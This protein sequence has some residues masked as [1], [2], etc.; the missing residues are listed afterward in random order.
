MS[1]IYSTDRATSLLMQ[2]RDICNNLLVNN[3]SLGNDIDQKSIVS[4]T[5]SPTTDIVYIYCKNDYTANILYKQLKK[6]LYTDN[7]MPINQVNFDI[8]GNSFCIELEF[9]CVESIKLNKK[10]NLTIKSI[11]NNLTIIWKQLN[12]FYLFLFF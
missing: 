9:A 4:L 8:V 12:Q 11:K 2:I 10:E 3:Y 7:K 6:L 1:Y 5:Y